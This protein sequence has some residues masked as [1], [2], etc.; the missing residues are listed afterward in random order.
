MAFAVTW[1]QAHVIHKQPVGPA[2]KYPSEGDL[3]LTAEDI[4]LRRSK[5]LLNVRIRLFLAYYEL[6][7]GSS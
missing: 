4:D 2:E 5:V 1:V 6:V 3:T 7:F